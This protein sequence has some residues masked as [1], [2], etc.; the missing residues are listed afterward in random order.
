VRSFFH[1]RKSDLKTI[2]HDTG[3]L[4]SL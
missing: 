2:S 1:N 4:V 3:T